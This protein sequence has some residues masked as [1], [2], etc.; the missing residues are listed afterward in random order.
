MRKNIE[1]GDVREIEER[2]R[3]GLKRGK[4]AG[5]GVEQRRGG[6]NG[7]SRKSHSPISILPGRQGP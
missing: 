5:V 7:Q 3:G 4:V 1:E 6:E 2:R